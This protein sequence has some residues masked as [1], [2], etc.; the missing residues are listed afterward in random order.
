MCPN[1]SIP[2]GNA[3]LKLKITTK[4]DFS[5]YKIDLSDHDQTGLP[6][7]TTCVTCLPTK[8]S[9][10]QGLLLPTWNIT[11]ISRRKLVWNSLIK[12]TSLVVH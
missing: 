7:F 5:K 6:G 11:P 9:T 3:K 10:F 2:F 4:T 12:T 1:V 8:V